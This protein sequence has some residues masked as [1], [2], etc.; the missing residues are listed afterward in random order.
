[1]CK[2]NH[3]NRTKDNGLP[4]KGKIVRS[5]RRAPKPPIDHLQAHEWAPIFHKTLLVQTPVWS[6]SYMEN[7]DHMLSIPVEAPQ[8]GKLIRSCR[9]LPKKK[10]IP[11]HTHQTYGNIYNIIKYIY[12][13][14]GSR[15]KIMLSSELVVIL[16]GR[17]QL[18]F[19]NNKT[20]H[21]ELK[22]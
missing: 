11:M 19:T 21:H 2:F 18:L 16:G 22:M 1:M 14:R 3:V 6:S 4:E 7:W 13:L 12:H 5:H 20:N 17:M 10:L 9:M 15:W 8:D